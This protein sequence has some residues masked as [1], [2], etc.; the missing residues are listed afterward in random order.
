MNEIMP[1]LATWRDLVIVIL[2]EPDKDKCR[3]IS[4]I[5][6]ILTMKQVNLFTKQ[7][8]T[9]RHKKQ[10]LEF[11]GNKDPMLSLLWLRFDPWPG[12]SMYHTHSQRNKQNL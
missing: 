5:C 11:P 9:H 6:G 10:S 7:K 3:M 1:F 4:H 8:Q 12:T 2:S